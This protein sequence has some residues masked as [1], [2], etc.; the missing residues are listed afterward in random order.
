MLACHFTCDSCDGPA[1]S[2]CLTCKSNR[3]KKGRPS[4]GVCLCPGRT[5]DDNLNEKCESTENLYKFEIKEWRVEWLIEW[6]N[7]LES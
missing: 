2:D 1:Y 6:M 7:D 4:Y 3:G 5:V